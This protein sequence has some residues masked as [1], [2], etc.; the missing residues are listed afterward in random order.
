M[1]SETESITTSSAENPSRAA[2]RRL[3]TR[4]LLRNLPED[5]DP[6]LALFHFEQEMAEQFA[7]TRLSSYVVIPTL[8]VG[9]GL[10]IGILR[11]AYIG[12]AWVAV[13]LAAHAFAM[14]ASKRFLREGLGQAN[15][16]LWKQ[17]FIQRDL[18]YGF[19]WATFPLLLPPSADQEIA[20]GI[21]I[22]RL[23]AVLVV[24]AVGALLSSP[25]PA[26][27]VGQHATDRALHGPSCISSSRP[28]STS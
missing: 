24:L 6:R 22:L 7:K 11:D 1:V 20:G 18:I 26:A 27:A 21:A 13:M 19:C 2:R 16:S 5:S 17:R 28:S 15:L 9:S 25:I 14:R 10:T 8:I 3:I 12:L 23:A 4:A